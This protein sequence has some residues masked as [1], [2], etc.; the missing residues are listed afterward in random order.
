[1]VFRQGDVAIPVSTEVNGKI[2]VN[3]SP[4]SGGDGSTHTSNHEILFYAAIGGASIVVVLGLL[5]LIQGKPK[6][7]SGGDEKNESENTSPTKKD[8]E[9][10]KSNFVDLSFREQ[11]QHL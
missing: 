7:L 1:M 3:K 4:G 11:N 8:V 2:I 6:R 9:L 5:K 10:T